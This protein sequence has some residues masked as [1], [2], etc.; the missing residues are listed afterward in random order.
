MPRSRSS[1]SRPPRTVLE[2][3][4]AVRGIHRGAFTAARIAQYAMTWV[5]LG[6]FPTAVEYASS[7]NVDERTAW[8]H[9]AEFEEVF[10]DRWREVVDQ[11][12]DEVRRRG[13]KSPRSLISTEVIA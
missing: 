12:A 11:V 3:C 2:A 8:R 13:E 6:H 5:E 9:R 1:V 7:W 4:I 10:G